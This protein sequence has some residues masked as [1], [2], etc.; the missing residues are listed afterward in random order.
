M[1]SKRKFNS[2]FKTKVVLEVL[3]GQKTIAEIAAK[4]EL[5]SNQVI[6]WKKD[7]LSKAHIVFEEDSND[8]KHLEQERDRLYQQIGKLQV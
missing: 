4:Y 1:K 6:K 2:D 5:Q 8:T 3:Q 7:F